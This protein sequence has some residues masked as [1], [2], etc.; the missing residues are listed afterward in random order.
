MELFAMSVAQQ[1]IAV[2]ERSGTEIFD[3]G[4]ARPIPDEMSQEYAKFPFPV[5]IL[6]FAG[7]ITWLGSRNKPSLSNHEETRGAD[8]YRD[9]LG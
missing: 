7:D 8:A 6:D 9:G 4:I 2:T 3:L 5:L 1:P